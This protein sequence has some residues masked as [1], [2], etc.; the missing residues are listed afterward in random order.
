MTVSSDIHEVAQTLTPRDSFEAALHLAEDAFDWKA[1]TVVP[2]RG[3][4]RELEIRSTNGWAEPCR[5]Y[6]CE[7]TASRR[8]DGF[9]VTGRDGRWLIADWLRVAEDWDAVHLS[10]FAYLCPAEMLI[11]IDEEYASVIGGWGPDSTLWL[12]DAAREWG[13]L[14]QRWVRAPG[15]DWVQLLEPTEG[16]ADER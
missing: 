12:T 7:V 2:V 6:P 11:E 9:R 3:A 10:T 13:Q 1:A 8:H 4:S 15:N 14:R 5:T 16:A